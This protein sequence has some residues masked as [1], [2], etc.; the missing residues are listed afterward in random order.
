MLH[1]RKLLMRGSG[2][3]RGTS[4]VISWATVSTA[5]PPAANSANTLNSLEA[6]DITA[7]YWHYSIVSFSLQTLSILLGVLNSR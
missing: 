2:V 3:W 4:R 7:K 1:E 6:P 5:I